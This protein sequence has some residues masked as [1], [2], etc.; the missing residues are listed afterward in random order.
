MGPGETKVFSIT[1][2]PKMR[3]NYFFQRSQCFAIPF[4]EN[5]QEVM[6][7]SMAKM[8]K[9]RKFRIN[10]GRNS[11][12]N[13]RNSYNSKNNG[14]LLNNTGD[15]DEIM[16]QSNYEDS[17]RLPTV[18][19]GFECI[20]HSF[21]HGAQPFI[22]MINILPHS[23]VT[24]SPCGIGQSTFTSIQLLNKTDTPAFF[25]FEEDVHKNFE[26]FPKHGMIYGH[27][28]KIIIIK[29]TPKEA[30]LYGKTL[31]CWLNNSSDHIKVK[32]NGYCCKPLLEIANKG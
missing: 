14:D 13:L 11:R 30:K 15:L 24:L 29:F 18:E 28:F 10:S 1:F 25:K 22:P 2:K 6:N 9:S 16:T 31:N 7:N 3:N 17:N 4:E 5:M 26:V 20:G 8:N 23:E 19:L 27:K 21:N 12:T 32:L